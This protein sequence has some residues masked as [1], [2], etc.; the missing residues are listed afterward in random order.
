[1][2]IGKVYAFYQDYKVTKD[3]Y[4]YVPYECRLIGTYGHDYIFETDAHETFKLDSRR[5]SHF[6][7]LDDIKRA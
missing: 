7:K 3:G 2:E 4:E 1:M 5:L 6:R